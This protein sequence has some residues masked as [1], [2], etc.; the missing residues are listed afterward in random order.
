MRKPSFGVQLQVL[1]L[2]SLVFPALS[3]A[4]FTWNPD[5]E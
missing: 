3:L 4:Q 2:L 5:D 1:T